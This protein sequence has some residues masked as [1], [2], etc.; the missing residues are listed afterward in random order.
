MRRQRPVEDSALPRLARSVPVRR[1][2]D[3]ADF[4]GVGAGVR[5]GG[6]DRP[7]G[8]APADPV[9]AGGQRTPGGPD[10]LAKDPGASSARRVKRFEHDEA[11]SFAPHVG[12]GTGLAQDVHDEW[13]G[14]VG[15]AGQTRPYPAG[16]DGRESAR[17]RE[18]VHNRVREEERREAYRP[19]AQVAVHERDRGD[20][21]AELR[22]DQ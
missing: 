5:E 13:R 14:L 18:R 2:V 21:V 16:A 22:A 10:D 8:R 17:D 3:A 15:A 7:R 1:D 4:R 20:H 11:R 9:G 19:A 6:G 12:S